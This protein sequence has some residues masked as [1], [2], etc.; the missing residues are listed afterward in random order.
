MN[1]GM[2]KIPA[3]L[4]EQWTAFIRKAGGLGDDRQRRLFGRARI[5]TEQGYV[6]FRSQIKQGVETAKRP[7]AGKTF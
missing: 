5:A 6:G 7:S 2:V 3:G 4:G 1:S